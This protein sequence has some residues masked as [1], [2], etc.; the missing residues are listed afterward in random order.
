MRMKSIGL[1]LLAA[2]IAVSAPVA[3]GTNDN[4]TDRGTDFIYLADP[5][6]LSDSD[7]YYL[8]GTS[9]ST[10]FQVYR[11]RDLKDWEGPLGNIEGSYALK[12][13]VDCHVK[14]RFWAPQVFLH[15]GKY[16]IFYAGDNYLVHATAD[17]PLGPFRESTMAAIPSKEQEIDPFVF[18]DRDGTP[19]IYW[20]NRYSGSQDILAARMTPDLEEIERDTQ[21]LCF[22]TD[23]TGWE[24]DNPRN[25]KIVEGPAVVEHEGT[26]YMLYSAN[27]CNDVQYAIGV[28]TA[29]SPLGPWRK[30]ILPIISKDVVGENGPGHGDIFHDK[31]GKLMYVFHVH[32]DKTK[33]YPRRTALIELQFR[34][35][36]LLPVPGTFRLLTVQKGVSTTSSRWM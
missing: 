9:L 17:S 34:N 32:H 26:Y 30:P 2:V 24:I 28:A 13:G 29:K 19:Y 10:G 16:H 20:S 27:G 22:K 14:G 15:N 35:G 31:E 36:R 18:F 25:Q 11:S 1:F 21:T 23:L 8:Y 6:I 3:R 5:T 4:E 7:W 12:K 33:P